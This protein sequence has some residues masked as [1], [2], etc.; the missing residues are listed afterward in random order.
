MLSLE[1]VPE[2][3]DDYMAEAA[4]CFRYGFDKACLSVCRTALEESL[5]R[6]MIAD[7]HSIKTDRATTKV[8]KL[9]LRKLTRI[10]YLDDP[11]SANQIR[12]WGNKAVHG[13]KNGKISKK[14]FEAEL[15]SLSCT[16]SA[17]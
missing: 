14:E 5:K 15:K 12:C 4:A 7:E 16:P 8:L 2:A 13:P 17:Y 6:R 3:V 10:N 9:S 1:N 11:E